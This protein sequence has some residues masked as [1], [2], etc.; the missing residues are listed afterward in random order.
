[1]APN[2]TEPTAPAPRP[3]HI[4]APVAPRYLLSCA[5]SLLGNSVAGVILPLILLATTGDPLAAGTLALICAAP[6]M[7][8]GLVGGALIDRL[9]R[10]NVSI[11]SDIMSAA[12][13]AMLPVVDMIWG[14]NFS[15]FVVLGLIG[16]IGDIPGM[17]ARDA[18]LP[19]V[20]ERDGKSLQKFMG[21]TQSLDSLTVIAGP[22]LAAFLMAVIGNASALWFTAAMSFAA[23]L[24]T[25]TLPRSIG[26]TSASDT[27]EK[28]AAASRG[29]VR[30]A[31]GS[32]KSGVRVLFK[33]DALL[34]A[35]MLLT[36]GIVM[37]MGSFQGL[38]LPV[39]FTNLGQPELLGFVLSAMSAGMLVS[40]LLYSATAH[41]LRRRTWFTLSLAGMAAGLLTLGLLPDFPVMVAGAV[42]LGL[43]A[44]PA[45]A[46]MGFFVFDRIPAENRGAALGTQNS[47]MLVAAPVAV[48]AAS[49]VTEA[50]GPAVAGIALIA[51]WMAVTVWALNA[52]SLKD[53]GDAERPF[54][55]PVPLNDR[56][57]D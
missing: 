51:C 20:C 43:S 52:H 17:T 19:A 56:C 23:A 40:S 54:P 49:A 37:I 42:L 39:H 35:S 55:A 9:N 38:V 8:I 2:R 44:G 3:L 33:S 45:S 14:L 50:F 4:G 46:L 22:A 53:L 10:R 16:A 34:R 11:V 28:K 6:Q 36:F 15:W 41:K 12:S 29:L 26:R 18:L 30:D 21:L 32:L 5:L 13:V 1:M 7:I 25:F 31:V 57:C 27:A 48:F 47:L 24:V